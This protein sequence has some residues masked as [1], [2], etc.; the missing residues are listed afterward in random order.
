MSTVIDVP[1][2]DVPI[3][4]DPTLLKVPSMNDDAGKQAYL[5]KI[6]S[7]RNQPSTP[8]AAPATET[9]VPDSPTVEQAVEPEAHSDEPASIDARPE[10]AAQDTAQSRTRLSKDDLAEYEIPVTDENGE[11]VYLSYDDFNKTVGTYS[12][13]NKKLREL[14]EREREVEALKT[15]LVAEST[16]IIGDIGQREQQMQQRYQWVQESLAFAHQHGIETI[17]FE[18]GTTR[19]V[20][21]LI[22]EKT[23]LETEYNKL[24][25]RRQEA[26]TAVQ[27]AQE[28]FVRKQ[29]TVLQE[30][31]PNIVKSR[32]DIVKFLERQGF[33]NEESSAL[34]YSKAELL[35]LIDKAMRWENAQRGEAKEKKVASNTKVLKNP[36]RLA[37]RG[38]PVNSQASSRVQE[39]RS[40]GTKASPDQLR[41]LRRLQLQNR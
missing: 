19:R 1:R 35:I 38:T 26:Q 9:V 29:D 25:T 40:L 5:Q 32:P 14:A 30:R 12:K 23:A 17:K 4:S 6:R 39:L 24:N 10:S 33:T 27:R 7:L 37:G 34:A 13:Q 20:T 18:D 3:V 15:N 36:S 28:D 41:E 21:Q 2:S 11:T 31:A 16:K 8:A 22:A